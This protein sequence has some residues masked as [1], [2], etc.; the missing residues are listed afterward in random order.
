[1]HH[2]QQ[3][4]VWLK[5]AHSPAQK[6]YLRWKVAMIESTRLVH[7]RRF[8]VRDKVNHHANGKDY[9]VCTANMYGVKYFRVLRKWMYPADA[10]SPRHILKYM[11]SPLSL[12]IVFMDDGCVEK[13]KRK[14]LDGSEYY[15]AP[16][17]SLALFQPE[18]ES[19]EFLAWVAVTFGVQ[20]YA[21]LRRRKEPGATPYFVLMFNTE[22]SKR[23]WELLAP[24]V[25]PLASMQKKFAFCIE[26][27]GWPSTVTTGVARV[28]STCLAAGEDIVR[29]PEETPGRV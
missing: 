28:P 5:L 3:G 8:T 6:D 9:P 4:S 12:A 10:K 29:H 24:F 7:G 15:L 23:L 19:L 2:K 14:N 18:E 22:N 13:R 21:T 20:G 16:R 17:M 1:M 25:Y 27:W 26:R 11:R